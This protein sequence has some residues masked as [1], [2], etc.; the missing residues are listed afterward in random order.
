MLTTET[1]HQ[2]STQSQSLQADSASR[3]QTKIR[4]PISDHGPSILIDKDDEKLPSKMELGSSFGSQ[5]KAFWRKPHHNGKSVE[6][7]NKL[8]MDRVGRG[9]E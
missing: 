8:S 5:G 3:R 1:Q 6:K 7:Q 4:F 9:S 2:A